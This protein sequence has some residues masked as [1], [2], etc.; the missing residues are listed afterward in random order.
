[1]YVFRIYVSNVYAESCLGKVVL[2]GTMGKGTQQK[3]LAM[4]R[5]NAAENP[6]A[7]PRRGTKAVWEKRC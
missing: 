7:D 1:M 4:I 5:K 2:A 6:R 3:I